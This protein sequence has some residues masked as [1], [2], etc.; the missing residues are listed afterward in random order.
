MQ[1]EKIIEK[2]KEYGRE[3]GI[4]S[5]EIVEKRLVGMK[6]RGV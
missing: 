2:I 1:K 6:Q 4:G 5:I 3:N